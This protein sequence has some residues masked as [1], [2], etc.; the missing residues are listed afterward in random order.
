MAIKIKIG[1]RPVYLNKFA[2]NI[3]YNEGDSAAFRFNVYNVKNGL[4]YENILNDNII[5]RVGNRTGQFEIDLV[6]YN[7]LI[8]DD[9]I[10]S[11]EFIEGSKNSGIVFSA[12][13]VN[14]G[15]YHR[16]ASHARWKKYPMGVGFNVT[17]GY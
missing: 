10:V 5:V 15:T 17:V 14:K 9:F 11:L 12:G 1:K 4:P 6:P 7:I 2:F 8:H 3:S 13:F 16:T